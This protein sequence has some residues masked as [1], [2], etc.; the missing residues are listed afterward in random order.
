MLHNLKSTQSCT[1]RS[2]RDASRYMQYE[3]KFGII[4]CFLKKNR[5]I[6]VYF[7]RILF[8]CSSIWSSLLHT[9]TWNITVFLIE[10]F[11]TR[12]LPCVLCFWDLSLL[13]P[14]EFHL[15][16]RQDREYVNA[17]W[18]N[19]LPASGYRHCLDRSVRSYQDSGAHSVF[20]WTSAAFA[21]RPRSFSQNGHPHTQT[22]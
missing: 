5:D 22:W 18:G 10:W 21:D 4:L 3:P 11:V 9:N 17:F 12:C 1:E 8:F 13:Y 15:L 20:H 16:G 2:R 7:Q 19:A 14:C 6:L